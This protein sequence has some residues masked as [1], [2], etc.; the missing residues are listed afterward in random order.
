MGGPVRLC[1]G[2]CGVVEG[3]QE[4]EVR[5]CWDESQWQ[6]EHGVANAHGSSK[7]GLQGRGSSV[8]AALVSRTLLSYHTDLTSALNPSCSLKFQLC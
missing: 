2:I 1:C 3:L 4:G 8:P 5:G 7:G 6:Q